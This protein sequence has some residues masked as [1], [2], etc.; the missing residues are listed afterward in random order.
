MVADLL[1]SPADVG[2]SPARVRHT[3]ALLVPTEAVVGDSVA[4]ADRARVFVRLRLRDP[5]SGAER[6][7]PAF[8]AHAPVLRGGARQRPDEPFELDVGGDEEDRSAAAAAP[9]SPPLAR[10]PR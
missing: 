5:G 2:A 1:G 7:M 9:L 3:L 4:P 10:R 6:A 8:P